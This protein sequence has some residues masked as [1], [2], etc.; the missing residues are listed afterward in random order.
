MGSGTSGMTVGELARDQHLVV[1]G[2]LLRGG[3]GP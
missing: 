2:L 3:T 1:A